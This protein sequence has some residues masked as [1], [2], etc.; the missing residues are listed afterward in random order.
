M[1]W[2]ADQLNAAARRWHIET[3]HWHDGDAGDAGDAAATGQYRVLVLGAATPTEPFAVAAAREAFPGVPI[4]YLNPLDGHVVVGQ[5]SM[6]VVTQP[7]YDVAGWQAHRLETGLQAALEPAPFAAPPTEADLAAVFVT[8]VSHFASTA[9]GRHEAAV[10]FR[11][12]CGALGWRTVAALVAG[13][14]EGTLRS[15]DTII[16]VLAA[17]ASG[18]ISAA[19]RALP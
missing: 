17:L 5:L 13:M 6:H 9:R 3:H 15:A 4:A 19:T 8:A 18:P 10:A 7:V 16:A 11:A 14:D 2:N 12:V 1:A